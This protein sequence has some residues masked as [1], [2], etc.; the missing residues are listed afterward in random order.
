MKKLLLPLILVLF[1]TGCGQGNTPRGMSLRQRMNDS[2]GCA[3]TA[4]VRAYI[5]KEEYVF[6]MDCECGNSDAVTFTVTAPE[7]LS[8]ITG[9][10][11]SGS[12]SL[13]FD[14][15][16]LAFPM[17]AQGTMSP[18]SS[19]WVLLHALRGGYLTDEGTEGLTIDETYQGVPLRLSVTLDNEDMPTFTEIF[20]DGERILSLAL[21]NFRFL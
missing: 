21:T 15:Q 6:S 11:S 16:A 2:N 3:F 8:G 20:Q 5:G 4:E 1:F 13:T 7:S 18:I 12:G 19:V 17:L 9:E 14:G 10:L